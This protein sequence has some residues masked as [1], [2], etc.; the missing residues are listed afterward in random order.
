MDS[1]II[2]HPGH[3]HHYTIY[4]SLGSTS[5]DISGLVTALSP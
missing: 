1:V 2:D 5:Q 4:N 3:D